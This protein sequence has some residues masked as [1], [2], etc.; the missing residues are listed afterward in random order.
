MSRHH[1]A[2]FSTGH[3]EGVAVL[4]APGLLQQ[5]AHRD[6]E[7]DSLDTLLPRRR[8]QL[9]AEDHCHGKRVTLLMWVVM[10]VAGHQGSTEQGQHTQL[11]QD[12]NAPLGIHLSNHSSKHKP[13]E[14]ATSR[15]NS[16]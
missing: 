14:M 13:R 15:R 16:L 10:R 3:A 5:G 1:D 6:R 11:R 7:V 2:R 4:D 12:K 9:G 8:G